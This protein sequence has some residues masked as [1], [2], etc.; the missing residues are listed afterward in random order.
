M[1]RHRGV[2]MMFWDQQ[3]EDRQY[4]GSPYQKKI[5]FL[6]G[7]EEEGK[8]NLQGSTVPFKGF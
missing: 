5:H 6:P 3:K 4:G 7:K 1:I 8:G 2:A